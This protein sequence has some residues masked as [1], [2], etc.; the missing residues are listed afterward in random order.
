MQPPP[1][2][3]FIVSQAELLLQLPVVTLNAPTHLG[4]VDQVLNW[5]VTWQF[6]VLPNWP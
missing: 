4:D 3:P 1:V 6:S 5:G 2:A